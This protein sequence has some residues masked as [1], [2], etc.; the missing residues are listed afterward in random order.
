MFLIRISR[1]S[2][3]AY[4]LA[5]GWLRTLIALTRAV[6]TASLAQRYAEA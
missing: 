6:V 5:N 1:N 4:N 2:V 3:E